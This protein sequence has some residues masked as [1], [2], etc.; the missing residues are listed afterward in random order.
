MAYLK[1]LLGDLHAAVGTIMSQLEVNVLLSS[2]EKYCT[3]KYPELPAAVKEIAATVDV[4]VHQCQ[5]PTSAFCSAVTNNV[6][7]SGIL[8]TLTEDARFP[9]SPTPPPSPDPDRDGRGLRK[10]RR[11]PSQLARHLEEWREH[12]TGGAAGVSPSKGGA[13]AHS[14]SGKGGAS[15]GAGLNMSHPRFKADECMAGEANDIRAHGHPPEHAT[16]RYFSLNNHVWAQAPGGEA[17]MVEG[18]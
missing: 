7:A 4:S 16:L 2:F 13:G 14:P 17:H 18:S 5:V 3:G 12:V 9:R 8:A 11:R 6:I 10:S 1:R 15:T